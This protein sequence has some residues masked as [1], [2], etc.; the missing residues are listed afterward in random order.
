MP[1]NRLLMVEVNLAK[2]CKVLVILNILTYSLGE[3]LGKIIMAN[4]YI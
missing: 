2:I 3:N 4:N 1:E